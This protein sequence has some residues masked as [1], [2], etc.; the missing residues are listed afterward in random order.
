MD[1]VHQITLHPRNSLFPQPYRVANCCNAQLYYHLARYTTNLTFQQHFPS[2]LL[3]YHTLIESAQFHSCSSPVFRLLFS[4][5]RSNR[6]QYL[7]LHHNLRRKS[8]VTPKIVST[9]RAH[10]TLA[11]QLVS[12]SFALPIHSCLSR[13]QTAAGTHRMQL[14][15]TP[16]C[17]VF[18]I[19]STKSA[20]PSIQARLCVLFKPQ[21]ASDQPRTAGRSTVLKDSRPRATIAPLEYK[22]MGV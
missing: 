21:G 19:G 6:K 18:N 3:K 13:V 14:P 5:Q 20:V 9:F 1:L 10:A 12:T 17:Q 22:K 2:R 15:N 7:E 16:L 4:L 11:P 8:P